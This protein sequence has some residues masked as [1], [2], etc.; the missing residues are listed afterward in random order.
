MTFSS[1]HK[2]YI[3]CRDGAY[4]QAEKLLTSSEDIN[5]L[6]DKGI[7]IFLVIKNKNP[8]L[9]SKMIDYHMKDIN[10]S[11]E[12]RT[13]KEN[14]HV[15]RLKE[16]IE[17][18]ESQIEI[19]DVVA[20]ILLPYTSSSEEYE[21]YSDYGDAEFIT[22]T[23]EG[24]DRNASSTVDALELLGQRIDQNSEWIEAQTMIAT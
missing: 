17:D 20:Q 10:P 6:Y 15:H 24:S 21:E 8:D 5:I 19:P 13:L 16:A 12:M 22:E 7:A 18:I 14:I 2:L 3:Y 23:F 11:P 9:L 1:S 4:K